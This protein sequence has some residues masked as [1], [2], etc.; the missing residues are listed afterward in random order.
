MR[1]P[2]V[3]DSFSAGFHMNPYITRNSIIVKIL[4]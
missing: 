4:L 3:I 2:S 1:C